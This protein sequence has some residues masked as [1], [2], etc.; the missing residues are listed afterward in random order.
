MTSRLRALTPWTALGL[1]AVAG[2]SWLGLLG[3][4]WTDYER[5]AA[6]ALAALVRG[7]RRRLPR[8]LSRPTA[9]R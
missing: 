7:R 5:E 2:L 3:F 4:I 9:A 6:P 1:V 8:P